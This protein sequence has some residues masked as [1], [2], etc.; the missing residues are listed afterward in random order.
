MD[1][2]L[3]VLMSQAFDHAASTAT[4]ILTS[5][6]YLHAVIVASTSSSTACCCRAATQ[7]GT[8]R[9]HGRQQ[10]AVRLPAAAVSAA[11]WVERCQQIIRL[12]TCSHSTHPNALNA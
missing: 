3:L 12:L 2:Q 11:A 1:K 10:T 7:A 9:L 6:S 4:S 5:C 8:R